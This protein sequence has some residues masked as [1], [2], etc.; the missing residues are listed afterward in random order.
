MV[1][2]T[3]SMHMDRM[4]DAQTGARDQVFVNLAL[5]DV[6]WNGSSTELRA[7]VNTGAQGNV[8][9][10]RIYQKMFP[11]RVD[12]DGQ[13]IRNFLEKSLVRL[14]SY[15]GTLINQ[16][17]VCTLTGMHLPADTE[18]DTVPCHRCPWSSHY[19]PTVAGSIQNHVTQL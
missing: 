3:I 8:L 9:P 12:K 11:D 18:G 13:P 19:R 5:R 10:L 17:G 6:T 15:G 16:I 2:K 1:F 7:K 14:V 4:G